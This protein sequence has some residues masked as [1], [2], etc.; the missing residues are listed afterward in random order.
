MLT[1]IGKNIKSYLSL[2]QTPSLRWDLV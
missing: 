1:N 2:M